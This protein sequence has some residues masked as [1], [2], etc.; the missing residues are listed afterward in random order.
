MDIIRI[1]LI[2][3]LFQFN[4]A[5]SQKIKWLKFEEAIEMQKNNPKK[6]IMDLYTNWCGPCK[7]MDKK[8]FG[9]RHVAKYINEFYYAVKFNAEGDEVLS[10]IHI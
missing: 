2:L 3:F 8:T 6:I 7:V 1:F 9:N 5:Y 4:E 10:L